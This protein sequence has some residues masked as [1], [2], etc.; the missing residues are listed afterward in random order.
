MPVNYAPFQIILHWLVA[1]LVLAQYLNDSA[2]GRVF[3]A[4]MRGAPEPS[5]TAAMAHVVVGV[6]ILAL[7]LARIALRLTHGAP[8][9]PAEEPRILRAVAAATHGVLYLLLLLLPLS[10][11]VAW[12]GGIRAAAEA[13][14]FLKTLL[15]LAV[16]L[17]VAGALYQQFVLRSGVVAR[18]LRP[19]RR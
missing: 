16:V 13:H 4:A 3:R 18:M 19:A 1:V 15:L 12:Y 7:A 6:A 9:A 2:I 8:P 10:G 11:L 14:E 5:G 17:H